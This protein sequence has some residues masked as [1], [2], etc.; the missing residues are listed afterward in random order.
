M[1]GGWTAV[2]TIGCIG[3]LVAQYAF[4]LAGSYDKVS[5]VSSNLV[6]NTLVFFVIA[7]G[8]Y[9]VGHVLR[10]GVN[11]VRSSAYSQKVFD[12]GQKYAVKQ[13]DMSMSLI[14]SNRD[15]L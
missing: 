11:A 13:R 12:F 5:N 2:G 15:M 9:I 14:Q 3:G 6:F 8:G 10:F 7:I 1:R 4:P